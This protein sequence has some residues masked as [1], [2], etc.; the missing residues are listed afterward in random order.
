MND[1]I[2]KNDAAEKE[3]SCFLKVLAIVGA[4]ACIAAIA[5]GVYRYFIPEYLDDFDDDFD[6]YDDDFFDDYDDF[7]DDDDA[8]VEEAANDTPAEDFNEIDPAAEEEEED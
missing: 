1:I 2:K 4:I 7:D 3:K 6:D 8:P 5:Y